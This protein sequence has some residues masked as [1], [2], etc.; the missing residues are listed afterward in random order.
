MPSSLIHN[1]FSG[2]ILIA[3]YGFDLGHSLWSINSFEQ[4]NIY[5]FAKQSKA[6]IVK[7]KQQKVE[8][9]SPGTRYVF[10]LTV[11][12]I[13]STGGK[14]NYQCDDH[15]KPRITRLSKHCC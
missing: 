1:L 4:A 2:L 12:V 3:C 6:I 11:E 9:S 15:Y 7:G 5:Y 13:K 8:C 10:E 14:P